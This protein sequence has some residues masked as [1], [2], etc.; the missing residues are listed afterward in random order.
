MW[1]S[2]SWRVQTVLLSPSWLVV[3]SAPSTQTG[4]TLCRYGCPFCFSFPLSNINYKGVLIVISYNREM[5][6]SFINSGQ[7]ILSL[8]HRYLW[9]WM[10]HTLHA[11][12]EGNDWFTKHYRFFFVFPQNYLE[13][14]GDL[15]FIFHSWILVKSTSMFPPPS[16]QSIPPIS[17]PVISAKTTFCQKRTRRPPVSTKDQKSQS[18]LA[19]LT[20]F[21]WWRKQSTR[22]QLVDL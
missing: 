1:T 9:I 11:N 8:G 12:P 14:I 3:T 10:H 17:T 16:R 2:T 20:A 15:I 4:P 5:I 18:Q 21:L 22:H 19:E 6:H 7:Q 13:C